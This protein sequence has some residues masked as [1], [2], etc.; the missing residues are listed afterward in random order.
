[1][2]APGLRYRGR[3]RARAGIPARDLDPA[4][5]ARLVYREHRERPDDEGYAGHAAELRARL[6][7]SGLYV[8]QTKSAPDV[9]AADPAAGDAGEEQ[10]DA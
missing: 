3:G 8:N 5:L 4:D 6:R 10:H 7:R 1:M 9:P 2:S